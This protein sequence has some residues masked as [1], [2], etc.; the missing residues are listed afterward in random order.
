MD[1]RHVITIILLSLVVSGEA[2]AQQSSLQAQL[3]QLEQRRQAAY[4]AGDRAELER[5]FADEYVHTNLRGGRTDR[6]AEL[7]FYQPGAFPCVPAAWRVSS[8]V[9][10]GTPRHSRG[11]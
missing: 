8:F 11:R 9:D 1:R 4:V 2:S 10:T 5:Q 3:V 6:N 7:E